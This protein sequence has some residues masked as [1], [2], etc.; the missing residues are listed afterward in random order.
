MLRHSVIGQISSLHDDIDDNDDVLA[1]SLPAGRLHAGRLRAHRR[2]RPAKPASQPGNADWLYY[3]AIS[4]CSAGIKCC[5]S[6]SAALLPVNQE[7]RRL[8]YT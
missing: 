3:A 1:A 2:G 4:E 8:I 7:T 6:M 5:V